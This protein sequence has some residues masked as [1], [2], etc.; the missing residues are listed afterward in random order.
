MAFVFPS[1]HNAFSVAPASN[2]RW[3]ATVGA[4]TSAGVKTAGGL[5]LSAN[6]GDWERDD[7]VNGL[8]GYVYEFL[9]SGG[10]DVSTDTKLL[11][12]HNQSNAPNR[13]Q[14]TQQQMMETLFESTLDQVLHLLIT[15]TSG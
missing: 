15:D 8:Q 12:W 2:A 4:P 11:L 10:Y 1:A 9:A 5:P 6:V 7:A 3:V 14:K 13:I